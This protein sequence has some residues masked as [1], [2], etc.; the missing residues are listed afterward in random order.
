MELIDDSSSEATSPV[1][2]TILVFGRLADV[3]KRFLLLRRSG[4]FQDGL[5]AGGRRGNG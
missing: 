1:G 2:Y 4:F 5:F 3:A